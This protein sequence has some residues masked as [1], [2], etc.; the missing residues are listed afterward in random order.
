MVTA[1]AQGIESIIIQTDPK[2]VGIIAALR[3][4][5]YSANDTRVIDLEEFSHI[6]RSYERKYGPQPWGRV[7]RNNI[8]PSGDP[9]TFKPELSKGTRQILQ[10]KGRGTSQSV[11]EHLAQRPAR[12]CGDSPRLT[13][14]ELELVHCTFTPRISERSGYLST[15]QL[16]KSSPQH[17]APKPLSSPSSVDHSSAENNHRS[18]GVHDS[19]MPDDIV[20][21]IERELNADASCTAPTTPS[22]VQRPLSRE[23]SKQQTPSPAKRSTPQR[24]I[25]SAPCSPSPNPQRRF[26]FME[27]SDDM[28]NAIYSS[29]V[30]TGVV[31]PPSSDGYAHGKRP[32]TRHG[33]RL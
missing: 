15:K 13:T 23:S 22:R 30:L 33:V 1:T 25:Q 20:D 31:R 7:D 8:S 12:K 29:V 2:N 28:I 9:E 32:H 16:M 17:A 27:Y 4:A 26:K 6:L 10:G 3:L 18:A 11:F 21:L 24:A 5:G 14:E 19:E